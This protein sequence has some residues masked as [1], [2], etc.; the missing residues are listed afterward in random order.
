MIKCLIVEDEF[1]SQQILL[2]KLSLDFPQISV[3]AIVDNKDEAIAFI[4]GNEPDLVFLD[5]QIKGGTGLEVLAGCSNRDFE[6]IFITAYDHFAIEALNSNASYYLLKPLRD[7]DFRK[8]VDLVVSRILEKKASGFI[9]VPEK[10]QQVTIRME[11]I[12]FLESDGPYTNVVTEGRR[13]VSSRNI[14]YYEKML[15]LSLFIRT[16]HSFI[17]NVRRIRSVVKGRTGMLVMDDG[18]E[19]PVAQRRKNDL[20][21]FFRE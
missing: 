9:L 12:L 17:V 18:S 5:V 8:G 4:D 20:R 7:E 11:D 3:A 19:V 2:R 16:H 15:P 1:A 21:E 13:Y 6:A 14:G 10:G